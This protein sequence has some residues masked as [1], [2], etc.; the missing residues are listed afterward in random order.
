MNAIKRAIGSNT[1]IFKTVFMIV[2]VVILTTAVGCRKAARD[3]VE[4][5]ARVIT[6]QAAQRNPIEIDGNSCPR[7]GISPLKDDFGTAST[8]SFRIGGAQ[9]PPRPFKNGL[10]L[11][12]DFGSVPTVPFPIGGGQLPPK[13]PFQNTP[14]HPAATYVPFD[15]GQIPLP[16]SGNHGK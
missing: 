7:C 10:Q 4:S 8:V 16:K 11:P 1:N 2:L 5:P 14:Q 12:D 6:N 13:T 15:G 9:T 3:T